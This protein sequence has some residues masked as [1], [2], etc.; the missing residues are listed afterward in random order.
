LA[1]RGSGG[2]YCI[3]A[4]TQGLARFC[5][6]LAYWL[7]LLAALGG[8]WTLRRWQPAVAWLLLIYADGFTLLHLLLVINTRW[9]IP[10]IEPLIV[11]LSGIGCAALS[12]R[13]PWSRRPFVLPASS[14]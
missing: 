13:W 1:E 10:L 2:E 9:R 7:A 8:W 4:T 5:G 6:V 3:V 14:H 12:A 11:V